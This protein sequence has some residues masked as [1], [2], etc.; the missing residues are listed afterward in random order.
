MMTVFTVGIT[1]L[2]ALFVVSVLVTLIYLMYYNE[3][4]LQKPAPKFTRV[5]NDEHFDHNVSTPVKDSAVGATA[6]E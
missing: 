3:P 4:G 1:L 5:I 2:V 6:A